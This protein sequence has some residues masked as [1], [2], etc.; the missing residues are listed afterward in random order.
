[1][2]PHLIY[3]VATSLD[4]FIAR[5][6]GSVDWLDRFAEGGNDHGYNGFYQASTGC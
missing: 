6:D 4:G 2:K 3:Y 5:P 1:M